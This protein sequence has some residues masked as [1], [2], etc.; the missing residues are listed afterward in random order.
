PS[1]PTRRS[2]DL[3]V[4]LSCDGTHTLEV[5]NNIIKNGL[6]SMSEGGTIQVDLRQ[7]EKYITVVITDQGAGMD[8]ETLKR[9]YEPFYST[10]TGHD[11]YGLGLSY[12]YNF[13]H[14][15]GG[16]IRLHSEVNKGT[17]VELHFP[18]TMILTLEEA[19]RMQDE[20]NYG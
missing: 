6:E 1:F 18:V 12:C 19:N 20:Q 10:K 16:T 9:V 5:L 17:S 13:M 4:I 11:N 15:C 7:S 2:S 14:K 8:Q 3:D